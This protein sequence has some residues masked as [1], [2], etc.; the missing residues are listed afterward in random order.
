LYGPC[1]DHKQLQARHAPNNIG[2]EIVSSRNH[3]ISYLS[4][5]IALILGAL[6]CGENLNELKARKKTSF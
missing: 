6:A 5:M 4:Y 3:Y 1:G 2:A